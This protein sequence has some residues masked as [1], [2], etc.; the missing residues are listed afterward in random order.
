MGKQIFKRLALSLWLAAVLSAP[1]FAQE[2]D[3]AAPVAESAP[4]Q[5]GQAD[6]ETALPNPEENIIINQSG[7]GGIGAETVA[8]NPAPLPT[9]NIVRMIV[10]LALVAGC[11]YAVMKFFKRGMTSAFTDDPYL[12]KTASLTLA[13]GK[14][15]HVVTLDDS[16][17][18]VGVA[19]NSVNLIGKIENKELVDAMNLYAAE[20][21]ARQNTR[22]GPLDF[23]RLLGIFTGV[24]KKETRAGD[25]GTAD[26]RDD[27]RQKSFF[28]TLDETTDAIRERR[29]RIRVTSERE[30]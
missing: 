12:K 6:N 28:Q 14:T 7:S 30:Q 13:P 25:G 24:R 5:T 21:A 1:F 16:A 20:E 3:T 2:T 19:D 23:S 27:A 10:V 22:R 8:G 29:A 9:F 17:F 11:L 26:F 18:L 4:P 15:V